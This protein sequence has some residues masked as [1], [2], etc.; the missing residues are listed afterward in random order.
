MAATLQLTRHIGWAR[1]PWPISL[2]GSPVRSIG[3]GESIE[4]V[5]DPGHHVLRLGGHRSRSPARSFEVAEGEVV[6][7][8]C[9]S[10]YTLGGIIFGLLW[11]D[12]RISLRQEG[13]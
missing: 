11:P 9:R 12:F 10:R 1:R 3:P 13:P 6:S 5:I 8:R 4:I 7:F 2:D